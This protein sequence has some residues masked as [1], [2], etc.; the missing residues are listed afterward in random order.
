MTS[1]MRNKSIDLETAK[2]KNI[3]LFSTPFDESAVELLTKVGV[4]AFKIS[5]FENTDVGLIKNVATRNKPVLIST[6]MAE[7]NEIKKVVETV[8]QGGCEELLLLHCISSYPTPLA[9]SKLNM[10][11]MHINEFKL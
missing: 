8:R 2:K 7:K 1:G 6:G 9:S 5:S 3:I 10:I 4:P 11:K